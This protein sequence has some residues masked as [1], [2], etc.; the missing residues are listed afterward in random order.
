MFI[1]DDSGSMAWDYMPND[2][3]NNAEY[4][5]DAVGYRNNQCNYVYYNPNTTYSIPTDSTGVNVYNSAQT[6]FTAAYADGFYCYKNNCSSSTQS[7]TSLQSGFKANS[8]DTAQK[9]YYWDYYGA[10]VTTSWAASTAYAVGNVRRPTTANGYVYTVKTAGTSAA[11]QPTWPTADGGTVTDGTVVWVRGLLPTTSVC[12]T[13]PSS[14]TTTLEICTDSTN[15]TTTCAV[16]GKT[17]LWKKIYIDSSETAKAQNFANWYTYYRT[18]VLMMKSSTGRA[19]NSLSD[20]YRVG[21]VTINPGN[22]VSSDKFLTA[23]DFDTTQRSNWYSKLYS[24]T[25]GSSTPLRQA[26]SRVGRYYAGKTDGINAGMTG[27]PVQY[28]CQQNFAILTTDGYWNG[29]GGYKLDNTAMSDTTDNQDGNIA[30]LDAYNPTTQKFAVSPRPIYDGATALYTWNTASNQYQNASCAYSTEWRSQ[31]NQYQ[32]CGTTGSTGAA[33]VW[34]QTSSNSGSTYGTPS[35]STS[36]VVDNSGDDRTKCTTADVMTRTSSNGGNS[37]GAWAA[38]TSPCESDNK[39]NDRRECLGYKITAYRTTSNGNDSSPTWSAW[40][41]SSSCS[42]DDSGDNR[43]ECRYEGDVTL[44]CSG[45]W[46]NEACTNT[47]S[48]VTPL[49]RQSGTG[50]WTAWTAVGTCPGKSQDASGEEVL[51]ETRSVSGYKSQY[52]ATTTSKDYS[53]PSQSGSQVGS[54][55]T[56]T[57]SW[58]DIDGVCYATAPAVPA[59]AAVTGVGPPSPPSN[60]ISGVQQW[61]CETAGASTGGL[62]NTLADIAQYY[63]KTDLRP[64]NTSVSTTDP[65]Y[66]TCPGGGALGG[67]VDVCSNNVPGSGSGPEDDKANWQHMTTFTM[68]LGLSGDLIYRPD[69]RTATT[70]VFQD[71]RSGSINWTPSSVT[72][73]SQIDDTKYAL[74]DLW[75]AAV[76]GRGQYFS[77]RDPDSVIDSLTAALS[78]VNAR[79]A[80]AAAAATSNLQPVNGDN[81]AYTAKYVTK[82]WYGELEQHEIDLS[83][84]EVKAAAVWSAQTKLDAVAKNACDN[85]TIKLFRSGA[86]NNMVDFT[87]NTYACDVSGNPTG[88]ASTALNATEKAHF[89]AT[90]VAALAQYPDMTDGV[91]PSGSVDQRTAARDAALVN[92]LRGQRGNE[93]FDSNVAGKLYRTRQH[94]LGD[95]INA[96]P[97]YV[98]KP[99][100]EYDDTGYA[101]FKAANASRTPMVY[102]AANDGM[103]HAFY[104]GTSIVDS[105]G[106][107]EA[108]AFMPTA[109]L[110]NLYKIASTSYDTQ[111]VYSVDGTPT[112]GDVFDSTASAWKSI[113]VGGLNKG[114]KGYYALDITDPAAPKALWELNQS[115]TCFS[116]ADSSTAQADCHL[117]Y[118]Y[119]NPIITKLRDGRWVVIVASGHN[120]VNSPSIA[121]DGVG[122]L[123]VLDAITGAILYKISTGAG[124]A[125]TPSGLNHI[126]AW[127]DVDPSRNNQTERV[128]GVDL[129]GNVWRFDIN[130]VLNAAGLEATRVTTVTDAAGVPQSITTRPVLTKV[131]GYTRIYFGTGRY[132]GTTDL[133][134]TQT[135]TIWSIRDTLSATALSNLRSTLAT[136]IFV[137]VG[138]G[139]SSSRIVYCNTRCGADEGWYVDLP[140]TGERVNTDIKLQLG[141]LSIA[142]NIPVSNACNVGGTSRLISLGLNGLAVGATAP[143]KGGSS[144]LSGTTLTL[145]DS[146]GATTSTQ[147]N[148][149]TLNTVSSGVYNSPVVGINV[150]RLPGG[151]VMAIVTFADGH[152]ETREVPLA[153]IPP[154]GKRV[155]WREVIQ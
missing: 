16:A 100:A 152:Q 20:S 99:F 135:Q 111:H 122:Y 129:L 108:W 81:F 84:G 34:R 36:C 124:S 151:K 104:A 155:S 8:S 130:D 80:S 138:T 59:T 78:G 136:N 139:S 134:T 29:T 98:K 22:P 11:T 49:C 90:K 28:S 126:S 153:V 58:T 110:P 86:T 60:C 63:Y 150:V 3:N 82:D 128:Y 31:T 141:T 83:T 79:V 13:T 6:S 67:S 47:N 52:K 137:N 87:W 92:Y 97:I 94:I 40:T 114:G 149:N 109:V 17:A 133:S 85:R 127:V 18:R 41:P 5:D 25:T 143:A 46:S 113:I 14:R 42:E 146:S 75:H 10:T 93:G 1:L 24:Q 154:T 23:A 53:G 101:T 116:S 66:D 68:G 123:Y 32:L 70:G 35:I 57:G 54:T 132:L 74:D 62:S 2:S 4:P 26:L 105:T 15:T 61:P 115:T 64:G 102:T 73:P 148:V 121:G 120:N 7:T 39:G 30:E 118:S 103:L 43:R 65:L 37:W 125:A 45:G 119:A 147:T 48:S 77:A 89:G 96:Q 19:F 107:S 95:I 51:C 145:R 50:T 56:S 38:G 69:Y 142:A 33:T 76:N 44:T 9:A 55:R 27:D 71:L 144:T 112:V 21:F 117:G 91:T 106:G 131:D 72:G 140:D 12:D 88:A